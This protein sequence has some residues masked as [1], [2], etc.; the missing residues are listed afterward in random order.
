MSLALDIQSLNKSFSGSHVVKD[1]SFSI[2]PGEIFGLL[3]PNGAGKSTTIN[4]VGG[5]TRID[6]GTIRIFGHDNQRESL[7]SRRLVGVMH[8]EIV[9][10][11]FFTIDRS[12]RIHPG[13]YGVPL[14]TAWMNLL[15][16]RLAL[17]PHLH[18]PMNK[19]SGG[20]KRRLMVAKA[21]IH[22]PRLLILD[23]PTAGVDVELRHNLW[24]FVREIN[25]EGTTVLLTTHYLEEA[26]QMC[27]RIAIMNHGRLAALGSTS[28][29]LS[30]VEGR[31]IVLELSQPLTAVPFEL[32]EFNGQLQGGGTRLTLRLPPGIAT[33]EALHRM[34]A[35]G[36]PV[37]EVETQ[38]VSLE[39]VFIELTGLKGGSE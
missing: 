28:H 12:L 21:L 20:L 1:L 27:G 3:G 7:I 18:K 35:L 14:D 15:I 39:D 4:M 38:S 26:Q 36:L 5:V 24:Q 37:T 6:S 31:K 25:Q 22:K 9:T 32:T 23:E 10:D 17:G 33:G 34:C 16:E 19:L 30:Q 11:T 2:Q 13:Y 8:Q 29:L